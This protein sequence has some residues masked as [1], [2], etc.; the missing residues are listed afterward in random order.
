[1]PASHPSGFATRDG[2]GEGILIVIDAVDHFSPK[3]AVF[4]WMRAKNRTGR[5][6]D[7]HGAKGPCIRGSDRGYDRVDP[8]HGH[9]EGVRATERRGRR[10]RIYYE[11]SGI[12]GKDYGLPGLLQDDA[13]RSTRL[14]GGTRSRSRNWIASAGWM[15]VR[16]DPC[17]VRAAQLKRTRGLIP[18][19][20]NR[21]QAAGLAGM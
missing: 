2:R 9:E 19:F 6:L 15:S 20:D 13:C 4:G 21:G 11:Q 8:R 17:T 18:A 1:L 7:A 10:N 3:T 12:R 14:C 5:A 16:Q